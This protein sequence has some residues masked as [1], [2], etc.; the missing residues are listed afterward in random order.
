MCLMHLT[1]EKDPGQGNLLRELRLS[2]RSYKDWPKRPSDRQIQEAGKKDLGRAITPGAEAVRVP[3]HSALPGSPQAK[4]PHHLHAQLSLG[5]SCHRPKK[6]EKNFVSI[7]AGSLLSSSTL[8]D[9]VEC[10]LPGFSVGGALQARILECS[11]QYWLPHP[12]REL[13]FLLPQPPTPLIGAA[14]TPATQATSPP[15]HLAV[16]RAGPSPP[17]QP[18]VQ[19]PRAKAEIKP[20]LKPRGSVP[21]E[22]APKPSH[23][24]YKLQIKS[25]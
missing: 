20:Q 18:Q 9:A 5:Q 15:P 2:G 3:A 1:T 11:G 6:K 21:K 17:G 22:E 25:T 10:G 23:Q 19:T 7:C 14:R 12:S 4:Q 8:W 24:M 16:T 13:Y